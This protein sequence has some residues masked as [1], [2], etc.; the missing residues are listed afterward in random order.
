MVPI[1]AAPNTLD[2]LQGKAA[3]PWP[4]LRLQRDAA[5]LAQK[6]AV[7]MAFIAFKGRDNG[8]EFCLHQ[9]RSPN[10]TGDLVPS[11]LVMVPFLA[12]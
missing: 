6:H 4:S 7:G 10:R 8:D 11:K 9:L 1:G 3:L 2:F 12:L 5:L